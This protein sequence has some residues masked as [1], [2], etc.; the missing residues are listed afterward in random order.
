MFVKIIY[1]YNLKQTN[2]YEK[3]NYSQAA[4]IDSL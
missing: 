1:I 4:F 2:D 3:K